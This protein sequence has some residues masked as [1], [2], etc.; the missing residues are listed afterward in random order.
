M[1]HH[2]STTF[3]PGIGGRLRTE[4]ED[5]QVDERPLIS[6]LEKANTSISR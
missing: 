4:P 3:V 5:F 2:A 1:P 6:P